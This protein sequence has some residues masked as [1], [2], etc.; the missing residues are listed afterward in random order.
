MT[1][2]SFATDVQPKGDIRVLAIGT[3]Q[4]TIYFTLET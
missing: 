3:S 4:A 1:T 2:R